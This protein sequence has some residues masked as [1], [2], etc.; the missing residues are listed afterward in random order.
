MMPPGKGCTMAYRM[1]VLFALVCALATGCVTN[2]ATGQ[3]QLRLVSSADEINMGQQ[4]DGTV[5]A[6]YPV[7]TGT[8]AAQRV[9]RIGAKI[10]AVSPEKTFPY[11]FALIQT[12]DVNAFAAPGGYIYVTT[13]LEKLADSDAELAAVMAH[14]VGHVAAHHSVSQLQKAMGYQLFQALILGDKGSP[15]AKTAADV[16]FNSVIMTGFSRQ[17]EYQADELGVKYASEAGYDPYGMADFFAKLA[18]V[19]GDSTKNF[20]FLLS[21]PNTEERRRRAEGMAAQYARR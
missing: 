10:A 6:E 18:K 7:V 1:I 5:R 4:I 17:D 21:H 13:A 11:H 9:E 15:L 3:S 2:P 12:D 8:P 20:E 16:A 14:E 19:E